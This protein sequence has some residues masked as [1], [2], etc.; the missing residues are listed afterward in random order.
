MNP[1]E[2]DIIASGSNCCKPSGKT[3][4][5]AQ[6]QPGEV[7]VSIGS[8]MPGDTLKLA[9][10]TGSNGYVFGI[11][12]VPAKVKQYL[13]IAE[14]TGISNINFIRSG[15]EK[16]KLGNE[17]ADLVVSDCALNKAANKLAVWHEIYRLLKPGGRF[18]VNDSYNS[19][20]VL[21]E[22]V[23]ADGS[24]TTGTL[25]RGEYLQMLYDAGFVSVRILEQSKSVTSNIV[26]FTIRGE[27][28]GEAKAG[29]C[30]V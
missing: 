8:N 14:E 26:S 24:C 11:E 12:M 16:I 20:N 4:D 6:L 17:V 18:V 13:N 22:P 10:E 15:F 29:W 5:F 27:K 19:G 23:P 21:D 1:N 7:C 9:E 25:T 3:S 30:R 2:T 28:P